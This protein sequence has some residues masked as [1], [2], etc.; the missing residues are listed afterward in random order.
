EAMEQRAA[1]AQAGTSGGGVKGVV[2]R[3]AT[4]CLRIEEQTPAM[5]PKLEGSQRSPVWYW[6]LPTPLLIFLLWSLLHG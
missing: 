1:W 4:A 2:D 5:P 6:L 3:V